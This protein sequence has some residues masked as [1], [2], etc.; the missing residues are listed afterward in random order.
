[1]EEITV[2]NNNDFGQMRTLTINGEPWFVGKDVAIALGYGEG[3]TDSKA[4]THAV[5]RYVHEEDKGV[6]KMVTPGGKQD[7][8]IINESGLYSLILSSKLPSAKAFKH[9]VTSE[10]LPTIRKTGKYHQPQGKELLALALVE[11]NKTLQL[12]ESENKD[13]KLQVAHQTEKIVNMTPKAVLGDRVSA[14]KDTISMSE[15]ACLITQNGLAVG[16]NTLFNWMRENGYF[17][18]TSREPKQKYVK[19]GLFQLGIRAYGKTDTRM[20][21]TTM[22]TGKGIKYFLEKFLPNKTEYE[23]ELR[24]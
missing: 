3:K 11:A 15:L 7:V 17:F 23:Y 2:F 19:E 8:I 13:L 4:V 24:R 16:R 10:V 5:R 6:T 21:R 18:K 12:I 22:V 20:T 9:W 14:S 1:M